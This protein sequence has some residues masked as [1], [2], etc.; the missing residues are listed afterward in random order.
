MNTEALKPFLILGGIVVCVCIIMLLPKT[1]S[2]ARL[3]VVLSIASDTIAELHPH[4]HT[5]HD[6]VE[7]AGHGV[8][9][10]AQELYTTEDL[11][12]RGIRA[13]VR[14]A[15]RV[16]L[17]H[18]NL[19]VFPARS[20]THAATVFPEFNTPFGISVGQD[21]S[22]TL[23]LPKPYATYIPKGSR[24]V[25]SGM[26][27]NPEPPK[28]PGGTY[29]E[30]SV[31]VELLGID[32][33]ASQAKPVRQLFL[34]LVDSKSP[35]LDSFIVPPNAEHFTRYAGSADDTGRG[36]YEFKTDG[37]L[38]QLG[39]HLHAWEGGE[40]VDAYLNEKKI[41]T[42]T[43]RRT[44]KESWEWTTDQATILLPV[45]KGDV[46]SLSATY[47]NDHNEP[48]VGAMGILGGSFAPDIR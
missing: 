28:G 9:L 46:L 48:V 17:H 43:S 29:T 30:V 42:F 32:F 24:I 40:K 45:R 23:T 4:T 41:H 11:W 36:T 25:L 19:L 38:V 35:E 33:E 8:A 13:Q 7:S 16:T 14:N 27:H 1:E 21:I 12:V 47:S 10:T 37:M 5:E 26:M 3:P 15:P 34:T 6:T 44:G 18:M 22:E 31:L 20:A 39:A 2:E